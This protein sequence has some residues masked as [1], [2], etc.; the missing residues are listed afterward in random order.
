MKALVVYAHP[1]KN[2]HNGLVLGS[3]E[4][5]LKNRKISYEILDLYK[6]NFD[7]RM[8]PEEHYL[9][10]KMA[11]GKDIKE[12]QKKMKECDHYIFI[13]PIWWNGPPALMKGFLDRVLSSG[14]AYRYVPF[15]GKLGRPVGMLKGKRAAVF[16]TT[17]SP[18]ILHWLIEGS[19]SKKNISWDTFRFCGIKNKVFHYDF[20]VSVDERARKKIPL[21]VEKGIDWLYN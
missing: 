8:R 3:V 13:Y 10:K 17:G 21:I 7:C 11:L 6:M 20:A 18:K 2:G 16:I 15:I 12:I 5:E 1:H 4:K 9:A 14:F 19:R